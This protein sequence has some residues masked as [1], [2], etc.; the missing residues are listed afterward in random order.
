MNINITLAQGR[1]PITIIALQGDLDASNY[2]QLI[3]KAQE[4]YLTG[5]RNLLLDLSG[6]PYM[7]S[8]GI[9]ALHSIGLLMRN[10]PLPDLE[11]GWAALHSVKNESAGV[12][13]CVKLINPQPR[14]DRTLDIAGLK[15]LF[16]IYPD[17]TTAI[18]SFQ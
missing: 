3:A 16:E 2:R 17:V 18:A 6:V 15:T 4:L 12:P 10:A 1:V 8:S 13:Q 9:V 7:S 5:T 11:Q 14:V